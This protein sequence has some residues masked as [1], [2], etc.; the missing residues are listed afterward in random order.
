MKLDVF[1]LTLS[2]LHLSLALKLPDISGFFAHLAG[3][4]HIEHGEGIQVDNLEY[5]ERAKR[6]TRRWDENPAHPFEVVTSV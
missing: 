4:S 1:L 6:Q 2:L 5:V 3:A